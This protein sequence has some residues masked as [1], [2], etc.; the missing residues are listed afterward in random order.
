M[1]EIAFRAWNEKTKTMINPPSPCDSSIGPTMTFDGRTYI[2]GVYQDLIYMPWT[3]LIT[4]DAE[5]IYEGDILG[6]FFEN[7]HIAFCD[8]CKSLQYHALDFC[9]ACEGDVHWYE[10]VEE[11]GKLD[12][13]GNIYENPE[14][15]DIH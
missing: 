6:G 8:T 14:L 11:D 2:N 9:F 1:K 13:I 15:L 10:L 12:V 3:G 5:K 4:K 7:G